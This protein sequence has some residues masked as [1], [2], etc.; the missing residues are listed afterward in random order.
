MLEAE[1]PG[2][3][4]RVTPH[5]NDFFSLAHWHDP[6][7]GFVNV[8]EE[9]ELV[10]RGSTGSVVRRDDAPTALLSESVRSWH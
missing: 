6:E 10:E 4:E 9:D 1:S 3:G 2:K 5:L 8:E 7:D